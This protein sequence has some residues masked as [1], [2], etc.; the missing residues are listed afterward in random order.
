MSAQG[1]ADVVTSVPLQGLLVAPETLQALNSLS[2]AIQKQYKPYEISRI[3][4]DK[5]ADL[6]PISESAWVLALDWVSVSGLGYW[7]QL[8]FSLLLRYVLPKLKRTA[9]NSEIN[10]SVTC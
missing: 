8:L 2:Q 4:F 5:F 9:R 7:G 10:Y 1:V 3:H 6:F